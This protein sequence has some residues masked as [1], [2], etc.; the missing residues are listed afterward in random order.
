MKKNVG[1]FLMSTAI[2]AGLLTAGL[3]NA[4]ETRRGGGYC[5][6][7]TSGSSFNVNGQN[8]S[9]S[10]SVV[11]GC[12]IPDETDLLHPAITHLNIH[13]DVPAGNTGIGT[14]CVEFFNAAGATCGD[15]VFTPTGPGTFGIALPNT[16]A[17]FATQWNNAA[18]FAYA[19]A[20]IPPNGFLKG[21]YTSNL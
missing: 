8:F 5:N 13:M 20:V 11:A 7:G 1:I 19:L 4:W 12:A 9:G 16:P 21:M 18:H 14:R 15:S 10:F 6:P 17:S 3:A 2:S